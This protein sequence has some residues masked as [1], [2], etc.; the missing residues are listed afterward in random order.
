MASTDNLMLIRSTLDPVSIYSS[1]IH[2]V[3][4][5]RRSNAIKTTSGLRV[6]SRVYCRVTDYY[7]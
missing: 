2:R 6:T 3:L 7:I 1:M 4:K 5:V